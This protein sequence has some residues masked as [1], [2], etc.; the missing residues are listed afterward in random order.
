M[1][2]IKIEDIKGID[3]QGK[4]YDSLAELH[5]IQEECKEQWYNA[6]S[7]WWESGY[8]GSTDDE[9][10]IGDTDG[11][12]DGLDGLTFLDRVISIA[13]KFKL[14]NCLDCG[15]GVGRIT[16]HVLL[17][18]FKHVTLLEANLHWSVR[19]R[20]YLGR[21]RANQC[22]FINDKLENLSNILPVKSVDLIWFQWCLQYVTDIDA[23]AILT[24][25]GKGLTST[26]LIILKENKPTVGTTGSSR[27]DRFQMDT[28]SGTDGRF[29]ITRPAKHHRF[30]FQ[31][32][33][34][35]VVA[36]EEGAETISVALAY[37]EV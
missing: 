34:L 21:K 2:I 32:A 19:S 4:F 22:T 15:A 27:L 17:K 10:M 14:N 16:K 36:W 13:P 30:L 12:T 18:R 11:E 8:G 3:D 7:L 25:A 9:A 1:E 23:I 29:D 35:Q 37:A 33:G 26:G 31:K 20:A 28:P 24:A 5:S 6:N